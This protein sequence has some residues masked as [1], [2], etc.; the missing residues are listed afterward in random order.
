MIGNQDSIDPKKGDTNIDPKTYRTSILRDYIMKKKKQQ[1][2]TMKISALIEKKMTTESENLH[3]NKITPQ[4]LHNKA[5]NA[6][7]FSFNE[8]ETDSKSP[9]IIGPMKRTL[10]KTP[11]NLRPE[12]R[13]FTLREESQNRTPDMEDREPIPR[14]DS[15]G[16]GTR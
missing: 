3:S 9:S 6:Q 16:Q 4:K 10:C 15:A 5:K 14:K 8:G 13:Q 12:S 11:H 2:K 7:K 1:C